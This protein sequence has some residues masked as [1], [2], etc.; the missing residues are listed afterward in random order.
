V[1]IPDWADLTWEDLKGIDR[2]RTVAILPVG[3][4]EAHGPHLPLGTDLLI[5]HAM[6]ESAAE[7]LAELGVGAVLLPSLAF[8]AAPFASGFPGTLSV[9]P[10]TVTALVL[11][12]GREISRQGFAALAIANGHLDPSHRNALARAESRAREEGLS[13]LV[14]PDLTRKPWALRLTEEFQSGACHAGRYEG[15]IVLAT[16]PDLVREKVRAA[17]A[18]NPVSLSRAIQ[19]GARTFEEAGG[20]SAYFGWPAEATAE[21]GRASVDAL[22][23]ILCDAVRGALSPRGA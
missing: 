21:E 9:S 18:P 7:R 5:A 23:R 2:A 6:A 16:R 10:E 14:C 17:L 3:A 4:L 13:P 19:S 1:G 8:T 11:D 15:S 12:L 22:G 20:P